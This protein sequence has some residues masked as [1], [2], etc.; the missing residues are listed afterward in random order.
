M[1]TK[2]VHPD[3]REKRFGQIAAANRTKLRNR[4]RKVL[5]ISDYSEILAASIKSAQTICAEQI[6]VQ[7]E[8]V[9]FAA[10]Q[11]SSATKRIQ[12]YKHAV[13]Q[14]ARSIKKH[15]QTQFKWYNDQL[16]KV[17]RERYESPHEAIIALREN[18]ILELRH[19]R[20]DVHKICTLFSKLQI[21]SRSWADIPIPAADQ[22]PDLPVP[23][24]QFLTPTVIDRGSITRFLKGK[25]RLPN[26]RAFQTLLNR[27]IG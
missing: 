3:R 21:A 7:Y 4:K 19:E 24:E 11:N 10:S 5:E 17:E 8:I 27:L 1:Q 15:V 20:I 13:E 22:K 9:Q 2:K 14:I 25:Q 16:C 6:V 26:S 18:L 12:A 23:L